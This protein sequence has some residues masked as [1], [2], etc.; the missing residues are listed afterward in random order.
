LTNIL[1]IGELK[2]IRCFAD[3]ILESL[4]GAIKDEVIEVRKQINTCAVRLGEKFEFEVWQNWVC[5][6]LKDEKLS[7]PDYHVRTLLLLQGLLEGQSA[8]N[9]SKERSAALENLLFELREFRRF[10]DQEE[11]CIAS[12]SC[13]CMMLEK[14]SKEDF[15]ESSLEYLLTSLLRLENLSVVRNWDVKETFGAIHGKIEDLLQDSLRNIY[16]S[17]FKPLFNHFT[18]QRQWNMSLFCTF[19]VRCSCCVGCFSN[20]VVPLLGEKIERVKIETKHTVMD[21]IC[22]MLESTNP[23]DFD[24]KQIQVLLMKICIPLCKWKVGKI[25]SK[26][27][28]LAMEAVYSLFQRNFVNDELLKSNFKAYFPSLIS[29]TDDDW[30]DTIRRHSVL[31]IICILKRIKCFEQI[32]VDLSAVSVR[33]I[34]RLDDTHD[35]I[36]VS[37]LLGLEQLIP[38]HFSFDKSCLLTCVEAALIHLDDMNAEIQ[39]KSFAFLTKCIY[40]APLE[41]ADKL[42][43]FEGVHSKTE[44][45]KQ[46]KLLIEQIIAQL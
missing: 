37:A 26:V 25:A 24:E 15:T 19:L 13:L 14:F 22:T 4:Q 40:I 38:T 30:D 3:K 28:S 31:A 23:D 33:L 9:F 20:L 43:S 16:I 32:D 12:Q 8:T 2:V 21:T 10:D 44:H 7:T 42:S 5:S 36:R 17:S 35:D 39:D 18:D 27:R 1:E 6:K 29:N 11:I 41:I 34:A 45:C 46:L